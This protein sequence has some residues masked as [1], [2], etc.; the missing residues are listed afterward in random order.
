MVEDSAASPKSLAE[1]RAYIQKQNSAAQKPG[2]AKAGSAG[3]G[4]SLLMA[5]MRVRHPQFGEGIILNRERMGNDVKLTITFSRVGR[6]T[7]IVKY[8][9]LQGL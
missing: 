5:G 1:L 8:A 7:L 6:K 3:A 9:K 4:R 2:S